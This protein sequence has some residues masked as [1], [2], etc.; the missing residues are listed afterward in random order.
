M[1]QPTDDLSP[2]VGMRYPSETVRLLSKEPWRFE[3]RQP[4]KKVVEIIVSFMSYCQ[5]PLKALKFDLE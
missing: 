5:Q 2:E 4:A 1:T 3:D